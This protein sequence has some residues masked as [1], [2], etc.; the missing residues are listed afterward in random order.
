MTDRTGQVYGG[1]KVL[2]LRP[3]LKKGNK[4][5][6]DCQC[7]KCGRIV[8]VRSD[9]LNTERVGCRSCANS[10]RLKSG[11]KFGMLTALRFDGVRRS[12]RRMQKLRLPTA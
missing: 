11:D 8:T 4:Q 7:L 3:D 12:E 9:K 10:L 2:R 5:Y 6:W 1:L